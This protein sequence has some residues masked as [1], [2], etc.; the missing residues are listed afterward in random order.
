MTCDRANGCGSGLIEG[1]AFPRA[2]IMGD[3][4]GL[5]IKQGSSY[6]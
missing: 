3:I 5:V 2:V 1:A 6:M 4:W